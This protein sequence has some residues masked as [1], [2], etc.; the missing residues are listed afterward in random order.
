MFGIWHAYVN[1]PF[2]SGKYI[3]T[4]T[5][6]EGYSLLVETEPYSPGYRFRDIQ[7]DGTRL[8]GWASSGY[9]TENDIR[10]ELE[11]EGEH[12][13]G[14]M[15]LP[16]IGELPLAGSRGR[17][18][19]FHDPL[20]EE[21]QRLRKQ[22]IPRRTEQD[23]ARLV[24][25]MLDRMTLEQKVGQM[26]QCL[27]SSFSFGG[28]Q[29]SDPPE[30]LVAEG[31][32]GAILGAY[33]L[34]RG[35]AL[36]KIAVEQSPLGIPLL[37]N[38]DILHG[39]QTIFPIPLGWSCSWDVEQVQRACAVTAREAAVSGIHVN[40]GPMVDIARDPRWGRVAEGAGKILTWGVRWQ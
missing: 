11:F 8:T 21:V 15:V 9:S 13:T 4:I 16:Y 20:I 1:T 6:E 40:H 25:G 26:H 32:A 37:L 12:F 35:F 2:F 29:A 36:Q 17:G 19:T 30:K 22:T 31:K 38:A 34:R 27:A 18:E 39:Y 28:E 24:Q 14:K 3:L 33:D 10:L 23:I 5:D 7:V